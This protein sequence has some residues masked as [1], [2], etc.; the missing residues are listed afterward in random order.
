[1]TSIADNEL[2]GWPEPARVVISMMS[3]LN[4]YAVFSSSSIA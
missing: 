4:R 2:D 1:M 3:R